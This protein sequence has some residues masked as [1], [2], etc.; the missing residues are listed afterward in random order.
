MRDAG[1]IAKNFK[2]GAA[3][4]LADNADRTLHIW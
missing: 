2:M 3:K 1:K 4:T